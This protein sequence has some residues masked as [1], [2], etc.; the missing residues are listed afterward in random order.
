MHDVVEYIKA[1]GARQFSGIQNLQTLIMPYNVYG[2]LSCGVY[3]A[4]DICKVRL[5]IL[6][7]PPF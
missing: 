4:T 3:T 7:L 2:V 5:D 6:A 1:V